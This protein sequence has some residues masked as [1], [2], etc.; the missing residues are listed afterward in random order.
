MD[1]W[2]VVNS[3][4]NSTTYWPYDLGQV[5]HLLG[6]VF[7]SLK[8]EYYLKGWLSE[9]I[10]MRKSKGSFLGFFFFNFYFLLYWGPNLMALCMPD[11]TLQLNHILP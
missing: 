8:W 7:H 6:S 4:F 11:I 2:S 3:I 9:V 10:Y 5:L 1:F